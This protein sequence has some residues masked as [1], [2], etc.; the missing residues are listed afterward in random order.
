L[1]RVVRSDE[2]LLAEVIMTEHPTKEPRTAVL[3][4]LDPLGADALGV[5]GDIGARFGDA[6]TAILEGCP[7]SEA[8][9]ASSGGFVL[10][11]PVCS[12]SVAQDD[13]A[14]EAERVRIELKPEI[15]AVA[16]VTVSAPVHDADWPELLRE[17]KI[18]VVHFC[19]ASL[20]EDRIQGATPGP[21]GGWDRASSLRRLDASSEGGPLECAFFY[22]RDPNK[23][24]SKLPDGRVRWGVEL[25][26]EIEH[27]FAAG[28]LEGFYSRL[29]GAPGD[30]RSA[31]Q[32]GCA[33]LD[34]LGMP[35]RSRPSLS[36]AQ[37]VVWPVLLADSV[38][39]VAIELVPQ[40]DAHRGPSRSDGQAG[41]GDAGGVR[42]RAPDPHQTDGPFNLEVWYGTNRRPVGRDEGTVKFGNL[43]DDCLHC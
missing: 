16:Q 20:A 25:S 18:E 38:E 39:P 9:P 32:A 37:E 29:R 19:R 14:R 5:G 2:A 7:L 6:L 31:F 35:D 22:G 28:F 1:T 30:F 36:S 33:R 21:A 3:V 13:L 10:V 11:V 12:N 8:E 17:Q 41:E 24:V 27:E 4:S 34:L 15:M 23:P 43:G 26:W 40:R 42:V